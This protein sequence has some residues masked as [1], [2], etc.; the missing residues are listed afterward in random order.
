MTTRIILTIAA[1]LYV[2]LTMVSLQTSISLQ[3]NNNNP[4]P[5]A[6]TYGLVDAP[7]PQPQQ[8]VG[9][10]YKY[11]TLEELTNNPA[12]GKLSCPDGLIPIYDRHVAVN[13]ED[14]DVNP[15]KIPRAIHATMKSRC[16][17]PDTSTAMQKWKD[18]LPRH[19]F[20]FHD[21]DAVDRLFEM[22]WE[23]FPQLKSFMRCVRF[24]GAMRIDVWR[25]LVIYKYGGLYTD[26][27]MFP[28]EQFTE[29]S[30]IAA[31]DE[32]FFLG[33]AFNRPSQ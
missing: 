28:T 15:R 32:A 23:E 1:V 7:Q 11:Y 6:G 13:E 14:H 25:I 16:L 2:A 31:M 17:S 12:D 21:D 9:K 3:S 4:A 24:K 8:Q 30:P 5:E 18:A 10:Q 22:P 29:S 20:Y 26:V 19:S 27:D 33:D